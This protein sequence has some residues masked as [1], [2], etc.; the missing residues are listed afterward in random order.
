MFTMIFI[1][2]VALFVGVLGSA[3]IWRFDALRADEIEHPP[4]P[5]IDRAALAQSA[6]GRASLISADPTH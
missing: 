1:S 5:A 3:L 2:S 4:V 6:Q